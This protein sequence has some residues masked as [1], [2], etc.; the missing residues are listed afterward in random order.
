MTRFLRLYRDIL[1]LH[2][3]LP[4]EFRLIGN[5]HVKHEF[6]LHKNVTDEKFISSFFAEWENYLLSLRPQLSSINQSMEKGSRD[7]P[8]KDSSSPQAINS[9][10]HTKSESD[11][12]AVDPSSN[13]GSSSS[14]SRKFGRDLTDA[15]LR[16]LPDDKAEQLLSLHETISQIYTPEDQANPESSLS[17]SNPSK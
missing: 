13:N 3:N 14:V 16:S 5:S 11:N 1:R 2:R 10:E 6:N 12:S 17:S 7:I 4:A 9:S 8:H 15:Q